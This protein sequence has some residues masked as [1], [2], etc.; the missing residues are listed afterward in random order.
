MS[1]RASGATIRI[2]WRALLAASEKPH[3]QVA[4]VV[5]SIFLASFTFD[6]L[7]S[8]ASIVEGLKVNLTQRLLTLPNASVIRIITTDPFHRDGLRFDAEFH[9]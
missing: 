8:A 1:R 3:Q 4:I 7:I 5:S 6:M 2:L 9:D